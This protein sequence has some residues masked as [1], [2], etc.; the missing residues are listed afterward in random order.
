MR[1]LRFLLQIFHQVAD[2][3]RF[4]KDKRGHQQDS[5]QPHRTARTSDE[6]EHR[7]KI[8]SLEYIKQSQAKAQN[9]KNSVKN[10][11]FLIF[12]AFLPHRAIPCD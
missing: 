5:D 4:T 6:S 3:E 8:L 7:L 10:D 12:H 9:Q 1:Q 2:D 11:F